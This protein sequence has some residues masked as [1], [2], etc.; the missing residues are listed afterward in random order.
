MTL[1]G[2]GENKVF[3]LGKNI[4]HAWYMDLRTFLYD[5]K[6]SHAIYINNTF[7]GSQNM[8]LMA[9]FETHCQGPLVG[10]NVNHV[11]GDF[12]VPLHHFSVLDQDNGD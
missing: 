1:I 7:F 2:L 12:D 11:M 4:H 9:I 5:K 8:R 3:A 6:K 10:N